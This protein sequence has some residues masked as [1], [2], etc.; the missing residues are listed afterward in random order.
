MKIVVYYRENV[1][2]IFTVPDDML[3]IDFAKLAGRVGEILR[4]KFL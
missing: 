2:A 3:A 4:M 1:S